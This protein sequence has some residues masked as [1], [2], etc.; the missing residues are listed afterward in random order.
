MQK[1]LAA[2]AAFA[3]LVVLLS[4]LA[5][6]AQEGR[7]MV[8]AVSKAM[9][10][11]SLKSIQV[12]G[13]G[14][15]FAL[16]Q[17]PAPGM[18]WPQFHVKSATR[19][20]NYETGALRDEMVRTQAL[21]PPRGGGQQPLRGEQR[22]NFV[23][24]GEH[25]WNVLGDAAVPT[26]LFQAERQF[27]LWAT[28]HG[29]VKGALANKATVQGRT[30]SFAVP[31]RFTLKASING[32]NMIEKV[33]GVVPHPVLG[34]VPV[35]VRFA[36][37]RDFGGVKFPTRVRQAAGGFPT[38][39]LT[40]T[41][42]KPN[43]P[44]DIP[45][46]DTVRQSPKPY[47]RVTT[48]MAAEGVWYMT[49]GSHH[50]AAIEMKDHVILV[51]SPLND[52]RALAVIA[53]ARSLAPGKPIRYLVNS[54][55][56]FDHSGG[57]RAAVAEG[58]TVITHEVNRAFFERTLAAPARLSPDALAKSGRKATVEGVRDRRVMTD[59]TR[60]VEIHH[61]AGNLHADGLIMVYLPK[62]QILIEAD[63]FTPAAPGSAYPAAAAVN[64]FSVNLADNL[65]RLTLSVGQ[66][67]PLHGRMVPLAE[68]HKAIGRAQ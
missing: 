16:G 21:D 55:H 51:E 52:E 8:E 32:Q 65:S 68:L 40:I 26:P 44:V 5:G 36:D 14:T 42:V 22:L 7:A 1:T 17:S 39:D 30:I 48:Q 67:L 25:A 46:P 24:S 29:V 63:A 20:V 11:G 45:V 12:T 57:V 3:L 54:H 10:A 47:A 56:H 15:M 61:V 6:Q 28:P 31:G 49:G 2:I 59:G 38:L 34:D 18:P 23:V 60:T 64:P 13:S 53:E 43:A 27:Q 35:E 50:S 37:Y 58:V 62:E 4:P 41:D 66:I 9:G 33:E 19:S